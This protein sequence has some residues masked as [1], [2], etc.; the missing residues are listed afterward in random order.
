MQH[1]DLD[2][3]HSEWRDDAAGG[4]TFRSLVE[5]IQHADFMSTTQAVVHFFGR[6][7]RHC[8]R[9]AREA[10]WVAEELGFE[11]VK[12][13]G[14]VRV[15]VNGC[16]LLFHSVRDPLAWLAGE[17]TANSVCFADHYAL[18]G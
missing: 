18:E 10:C 13:I 8:A 5:A 1:L 16:M 2:R 11:R 4:K 15:D 7:S 6:D 12:M 9:L 14:G 17:P 3:L